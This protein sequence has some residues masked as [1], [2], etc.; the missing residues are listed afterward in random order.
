[1]KAP[2]KQVPFVGRKYEWERLVAEHKKPAGSLVVLYGRRRV[3]KTRLVTQFYQDKN[4]WRF[5]GVENGDK[6]TQIK[7]ILTKLSSYTGKELYRTLNC[8]DWL[9]LLKIVNE[10]ISESPTKH[11]KTIFLDEFSYM[12]CG[13]MGLVSALKWA[14]D[15]FWEDK[16][17][18]TLVLCGSVSSFM[19]NK[20]I[21]SSALYGRVKTEIYLPPLSLPEIGQLF[22]RQI[23]TRELVNL[24]MFCGGIP[25]YLLQINPHESIAI[26]IARH[27]FC[28]DGY[29]VKEFDRLFKEVLKE[30]EI[31]K[32]IIG[33]LSRYKSL[34]IPELTELLHVS[35][36]GTFSQHLENLSLAGFVKDA[37]PWDK[38]MESKL[39]RYRL[40]DEYLF[41]YFKF[42]HPKLRK[43]EGNQDI[44]F[45]LSILQSRS[46]TAWA[47]LAFERLCLKHIDEIVRFLN[48]D[49][50]VKDYG[51]YYRSASNHRKGVQ[52]DL[53]LV[54][55]DPVVTVCEMKH[56][57]GLIGKWIIEEVEKKVALLSERKKTVERVLI[58][59]E[60][61]TKDLADSGY[62]SRVILIDDLFG[63][64]NR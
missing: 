4:L 56:A 36:G 52:I 26:N 12:A 10:A 63:S 5:D 11:N 39:K 57:K 21:K 43:I 60:G 33:A 24:Y 17:Q 37:L 59:T 7:N 61:I 42:I 48:I 40:D 15:N 22:P 30:Q 41:F 35:E 58:T 16:P 38:P 23:S 29:F 32:K 49:Q 53:L 19:V 14:W 6:P 45:G 47:G 9:T 20:V 13:R 18:F 50:L 54:R 64:P 2:I 46:Y 25:E 1:M 8:N 34:K 44:R 55:H 3:G 62:F 27:C 31:Y 28:K 51:P